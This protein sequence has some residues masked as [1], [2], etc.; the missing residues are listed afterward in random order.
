VCSSACRF[1]FK[2]GS[3]EL[4]SQTK[5]LQEALFNHSHPHFSPSLIG[6][7]TYLI[8]I[9]ATMAASTTT[10]T[11]KSLWDPNSC[12]CC[13]P[14]SLR[15]T[16][17]S[18]RCLTHEFGFSYLFRP[19]D[20]APVTTTASPQR[21]TK[22]ILVR[23]ATQLQELSSHKLDLELTRFSSN[24]SSAHDKRYQSHREWNFDGTR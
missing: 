17:S 23:P 21:T 14:P 7:L 8:G 18:Y 1:N 6:I 3:G 24:S 13:L 20:T 4:L 19:I 5:A 12:V 2:E 10:A 11:R 22:D 15:S 16:H 9:H